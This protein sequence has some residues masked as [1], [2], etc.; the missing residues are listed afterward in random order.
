MWFGFL[1]DVTEMTI[2]FDLACYL[3]CDPGE[4]FHVGNQSQRIRTLTVDP[5]AIVTFE[6]ID[7]PDWENPYDVVMDYED[8]GMHNRVWIYVTGGEVTGIVFPAGLR[9]CRSDSRSGD[10]DVQQ[11]C[12]VP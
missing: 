2:D 5:T 12:P 9:G 7:G 6:S 3:S 11:S 10:N 4:G 8:V 1:D